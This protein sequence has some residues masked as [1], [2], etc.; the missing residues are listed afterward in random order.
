MYFGFSN[1]LCLLLVLTAVTYEKYQKRSAGLSAH[2]SDD[3][4]FHDTQNDDNRRF[5]CPDTQWKLQPAL[6]LLTAYGGEVEPFGADYI[7][8]KLGFRHARLTIPKWVQRGIMD[9]CEQSMTIV[10]LILIFLLPEHFKQMC[11]K[12]R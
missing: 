10:Q 2:S 7:L 3:E 4:T 8:Q 1:C 5:I 6:K 11:L 9:P 12:Q